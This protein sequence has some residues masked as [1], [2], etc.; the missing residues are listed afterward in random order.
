MRRSLSRTHTIDKIG[1]NV[2]HPTLTVGEMSGTRT[3]L[4]RGWIGA[5][6]LYGAFRSVLV[7]AFLRDYGIDPRMFVAV[8]MSSSLVYGIASAK[9]VGAVIDGQFGR[10]RSWGPVAL[11]AYLAPDLYVFSRAGQMPNGIRSTVIG[12]FVVTVAITTV[13]IVRQVRRSRTELHR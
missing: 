8:E 3:T 11:G 5:S 10:L 1:T 6:V 4:E 2:P 12:V 13:G 7:W 9:A